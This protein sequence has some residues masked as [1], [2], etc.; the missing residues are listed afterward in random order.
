MAKSWFIKVQENNPQQTLRNLY[1]QWLKN[2]QVSALLVPA[3]SATGVFAPVLFSDPE[4]VSN[5]SPLLPVMS[6][7]AASIVAEIAAEPA[8]ESRLGVVLRPCEMRAVVELIKLQQIARDNLVLIGID[9]P[10]TYKPGSISPELTASSDKLDEWI[11]EFVSNQEQYLKD[12]HL[13]SACRLCEFPT[14]LIADMTIG[15]LGLNPRKKLIL[16]VYTE[17]GSRL[18]DGLEI[19]PTEDTNPERNKYL[20]MFVRTRQQQCEQKIADFDR[21]GI[22]YQNL[23]RYFAHCLNCH[24]CMKVCPICYCRECFFDSDVLKREQDDYVRLS[25]RKGLNRMPAGTLLFHL[26][27]MNHMMTSCVQCGICEDS[28]PAEIGLSVLFKKVSRN[29]Q[30]AFDYLSGRSLD[31]PLPLTTFREDEFREIGEE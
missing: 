3:V 30:A 21:V 27:R 9:C 12:E 28:C 22:G 31:E 2:E 18:L 16:T 4:K 17:N 14:P 23:V 6:V 20:D 1:A 5:I 25:R 24:N 13:R 8:T 10:G 29:A 19:E 11:N 7:N 15:F 26:T